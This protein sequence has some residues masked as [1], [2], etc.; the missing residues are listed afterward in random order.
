MRRKNIDYNLQM[1]IRNYLE[2][3][4]LEGKNEDPQ[5][6]EAIISNLSFNLRKEV[7]KHTRGDL[8]L[9]FKI[10]REFSNS[11]IE[12]L[13]FKTRIAKFSPEE[14]IFNVIKKSQLY[15]LELLRLKQT[16]WLNY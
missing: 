2:Y 10:F 4:F 1:K 15:F 13:M 16:E 7:F 5:R 14:E 9:Q 8:L 6:E 11:T 3:R 12:K